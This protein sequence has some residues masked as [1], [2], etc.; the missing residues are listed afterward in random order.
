MRIA[1]KARLERGGIFFR[2]GVPGEQAGRVG[3]KALQCRK[4]IVL[5][6]AEGAPKILAIL[7]FGEFLEATV[8]AFDYGRIRFACFESRAPFDCGPNHVQ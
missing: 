5:V 1:I 6:K 2:A 8:E 4:F 7:V 3:P